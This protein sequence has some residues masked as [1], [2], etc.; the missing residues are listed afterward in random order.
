MTDY[1]SDM[2]IDVHKP[3]SSLDTDYRLNYDGRF[4]NIILLLLY[5]T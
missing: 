2:D 3:M 5:F 4:N 1:K